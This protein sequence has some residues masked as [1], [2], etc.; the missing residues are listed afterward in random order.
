[1]GHMKYEHTKPY[2]DFFWK[3]NKIELVF[4][5]VISVNADEHQLLLQSGGTLQ[6]DILIIAS[7]SKSNKFGWP[8]ENLQGVHTLY[9]YPDLQSI[10]DATRKISN[11]VIVGGGLIGVEMAEMLQSRGTAVTFL[12]R[13]PAFWSIV[14]PLQDAKLITEHIKLHDVNVILN[15]ELKTIIGDPEGR[16]QSVVTSTGESIPCQF[17]GLAVGVSPNI[18]FLKN[19]G[20]ETDKGILVDE[21]LQTNIPDVYAIGDCVQRTYTLAGRKAIEQVWYTGRMMG[22][23]LAQTIC[24]TPTTYRPGPWFNSAKFFDIEY[25]TYG[26]VSNTLAESEAEFYWQHTD[27]RKALHVVWDKQSMQFLG[28][29]A[30]GIRMRHEFFDS[31]LREKKDVRFVVANMSAANFDPEFFQRHENDFMNRFYKENPALRAA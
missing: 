24:G 14:L 13:E 30:L 6:Y 17:V 19:S 5:H 2:E 31:C 7:G 1:M 3:K 21:Y 15:T 25:Q 8:G 4:D 16:V 23:V 10:E 18:A 12:I 20:I 28:I 27:G 26:N 11:A 9:G 29:N 22:E